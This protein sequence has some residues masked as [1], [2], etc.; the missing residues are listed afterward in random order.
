MNITPETD[1]KLWAAANASR[2]EDI[3]GF[4]LANYA[5]LKAAVASGQMQLGIE[6]GA[7]RSLAGISKSA[8]AS[9]LILALTWVMPA[10]AVGSVI[11]ALVTG[12][13]WALLGV[14]TCFLGQTLAN[15]YSPA[16]SL[17]KILAVAAI[18]HLA[19]AGSITAGLTWASFSF[20][21]SAIALRI[22]NH[23][24]WRWAH[25]AVLASEAFAA[26]LFRTRNLHLRDSTGKHHNVQADAQS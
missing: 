8:G 21:V 9:A 16:Q 13:W 6:Y 2:I 17:W 14:I 10:M 15:P 7:A 3:P 23:L 20:V 26:H 11:V 18:L 24:A 22:L 25:D 1:K 12:N 5:E 19:T 4:P